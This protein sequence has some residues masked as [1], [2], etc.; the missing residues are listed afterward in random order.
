MKFKYFILACLIFFAGCTTNVDNVEDKT[1]DIV[2]SFYPVYIF[3]E[4]IVKDI[5]SVTVTNM[6]NE[7]SGCLHD[8]Q[9]STGDMKLISDADAFIINGAGLEDFL[10]KVYE[11][12]EEYEVI[13]SSE[14]I[15]LL[16][17]K[18][19]DDNNEHIWLSITNAI[20][21]T[22]NIGQNL[23]KLD[24]KNADLYIKNTNEYVN[25]LENLRNE[26]RE[27]MYENTDV[28]LV[29]SHDAFP[30]L[31]KDFGFD[32]ISVIE[33]EEGEFPTSKEIQ[34]IVEI[35]KENDIKTIFIEKETE[36]KAANIIASE[37]GAKI[38]ELD[39]ITSGNCSLDDYENRMKNNINVIKESVIGEATT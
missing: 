19:S 33:K 35:V 1:F 13:D 37:T 8:Y 11:T 25:K 3:T 28:R 23:A 15:E 9:L 6:S 4:N 21:Q 34:E 12:K 27:L 5:P 7:H 17:H 26:L 22:Q 31:A 20:L 29:T 18:F 39:L 14:N 38:K 36:S 2:T 30:Y 16:S 10:E 24:T 32:V